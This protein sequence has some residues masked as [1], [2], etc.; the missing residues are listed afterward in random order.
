MK[1]LFLIF[2]ALLFSYT[3]GLNKSSLPDGMYLVVDEIKNGSEIPVMNNPLYT[4][5]EC[6][7]H[8][9]EN[10]DSGIEKV[11]VDTSDYVP[12]ILKFRPNVEMQS[13]D[14]KKI[15][16]SLTQSA[17]EKLNAFTTVNLNKRVALVI[18]NEIISMHKIK[19]PVT[20]G[21]LQISYC[22]PDMCEILQSKLIKNVDSTNANIK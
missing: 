10:D 21:K 19:A 13:D 9:K 11:I 6:S 1:F 2:F 8:Y 4:I 22:G 16:I 17:S 3:L 15:E 5:V 14:R 20:S 7:A 18:G 12:L